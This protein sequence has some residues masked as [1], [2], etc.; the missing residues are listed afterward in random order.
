MQ[1]KT[2]QQIT[3]DRR[4]MNAETRKTKTQ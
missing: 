3:N 4:N 2:V 1:K